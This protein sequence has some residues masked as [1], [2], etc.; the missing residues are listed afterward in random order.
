MQL[1]ITIAGVTDDSKL[2]FTHEVDASPS[3]MNAVLFDFNPSADV[4]VQAIKG[5]HA[6]LIS[7][8][9]KVRDTDGEGTGR[10][11]KARTANIAIT[12]LEGT[13]MRAVKALFAKG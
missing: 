5:M 4:R 8:M 11:P 13:Q 3:A 2:N 6:G 12:E 7:M 1:K 10:G 9:E